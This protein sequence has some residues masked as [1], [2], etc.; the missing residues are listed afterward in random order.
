MRTK[1]TDE[2]IEQVLLDENELA[3]GHNTFGM[4]KVN[5]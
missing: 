1:Q 3:E 5:L 2:K 4:E